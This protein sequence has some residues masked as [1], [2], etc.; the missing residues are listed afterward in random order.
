MIRKKVMARHVDQVWEDVRKPAGEVHQPGKVGPMGTTAKTELDEDVPGYGKYYCIPCARYFQN[1]AGL[2]DHEKTKPHKRT[3]KELMTSARPHNQ[4]DAE[5]AGGMGA[6]D[7]GRRLRQRT[8]DM[9]TD[10]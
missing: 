8:G 9:D 1:A 10:M 6:P 4:R 3:V 2:V 7:N 5:A